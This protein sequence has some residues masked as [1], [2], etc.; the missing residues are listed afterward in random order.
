[1]RFSTDS[2]PS[3]WDCRR[4]QVSITIDLIQAPP[5]SF[6]SRELQKNLNRTDSRS[7]GGFIAF[8]PK[9]SISHA[10]KFARKVARKPDGHRKL[11]RALGRHRE[12]YATYVTAPSA[13][14]ILKHFLTRCRVLTYV[15]PHD[16]TS[17]MP[18]ARMLF[19]DQAPNQRRVLGGTLLQAG[20]SDP[21]SRS[22]RQTSPCP[23]PLRRPRDLQRA[24]AAAAGDW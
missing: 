11:R 8:S 13:S 10:R 12:R 18:R 19:A 6:A 24:Y 9:A 20:S 21:V 23:L 7:T 22:L 4:R 5:A 1:M 15:R 3:A 17:Q 2:F 16:A 14:G